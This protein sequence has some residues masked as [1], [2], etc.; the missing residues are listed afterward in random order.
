MILSHLHF[1]H[2][3]D[4]TR[5][6]EAN[7][8]VGAGTQAATTPGWPTAEF[9]PFDGTVLRHPHFY[10]LPDSGPGFTSVGPFPRAYDYFGDGSFYLVDVPGH[11][12][13]HQAGLARTSENEWIVMGGDCCHHRDLLKGQGEGRGISVIDGPNG[14]PGFHKDPEKANDS[15]EKL[16]AMKGYSNVL[17]ILAHDA[18][19]QGQ[20]PMYP[21]NI[22]G[23]LKRD[24]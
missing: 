15:I 4:V 18:S 11:M 17:V 9:S 5:F 3:G 7:I 12:V 22:N 21:Y 16:R 1:D 14:Q 2:T 24:S 13:G 20:V 19:L 8:V 10:E 6:P 23:W